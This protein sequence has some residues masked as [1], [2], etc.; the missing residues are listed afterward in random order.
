MGFGIEN[1]D[2]MICRLRVAR[3]GDMGIGQS[4]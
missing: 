4:A 2:R 3:C 1:L